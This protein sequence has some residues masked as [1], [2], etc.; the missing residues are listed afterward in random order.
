[1]RDS[2][3]R[4]MGRWMT[5]KDW[6]NVLNANT[7]EDKF[8][9]LMSELH[10]AIDKFLPQ[11]T[12]RK[13]PTDCPW[14]T[15]KIQ[16][17]IYKQQSTFFRYGKDSIIFKFLR[18]QIQRE[19]KAAKKHYYHNRV[20]DVEH[21]NPKKW[22]KQIKSLTG[23]DMQN[24]W[25]HQFLKRS[26]NIKVLANRINDFFNLAVL[27]PIFNHCL[28]LSHLCRFHSNYLSQRKKYT[29]LYHH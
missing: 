22:W 18:N 9:E 17:W 8:N 5:Q 19:I 2:T 20:V 21:Q 25:Y 26:I 15:N 3:W 12:V 27:L 24:E 14:I 6:S 10:F 28:P 7:C 4:T 11:R 13:H 16:R 29:K 1:M 23:Q